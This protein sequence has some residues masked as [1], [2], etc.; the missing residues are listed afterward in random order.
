[1]GDTVQIALLLVMVFTLTSYIRGLES[2]MGG[3]RSHKDG[4]RHG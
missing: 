2:I 1:M 3:A 4:N